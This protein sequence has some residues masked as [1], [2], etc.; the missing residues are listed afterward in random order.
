MKRLI[1]KILSGAP[2][3]KIALEAVKAHKTMNEIAQEYSVHPTQSGLCKKALLE[4]AGALFG[5]KR[6]SKAVNPQTDSERLYVTAGYRK[7]NG[8]WMTK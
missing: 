7:M 2:K 6:S 4:N 3:A 8:K 5:V 1:K